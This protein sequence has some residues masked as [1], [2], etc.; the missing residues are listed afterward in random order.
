MNT[1]TNKEQG[2]DALGEAVA[3]KLGFKPEKGD[4][5]FQLFQIVQRLGGFI[6]PIDK[7]ERLKKK[8][9]WLIIKGPKDFTL[10]LEIDNAGL[11]ITPSHEIGRALYYYTVASK[12]G[13]IPLSTD[14]LLGQESYDAE[15]FTAGFFVPLDLIE[16]NPAG[17]A[18]LIEE[19]SKKTKAGNR[20]VEIRLRCL[21][22]LPSPE[23][24]QP[25]FADI[26]Q[27]S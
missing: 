18:H 25:R 3:K 5:A 27:T 2:W 15:R 21:G 14:N 26:L 9:P 23:K 13:E 6:F 12:C 1:E 16:T 11:R 19:T 8:I 4:H 20:L 10:Y 7:L 22:M 17:D 24:K